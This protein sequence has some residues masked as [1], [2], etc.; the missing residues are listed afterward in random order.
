MSH[1][2][3]VPDEDQLDEAAAEW[4]FERESSF[5][6]ERARAF[7]AWCEVELRHAAAVRR[8]EHTLQLLDEM[9]AVR[10]PLEARLASSRTELEPERT[11]SA[12]SLAWFIRLG[13]VAAAL[14]VGLAIWWK[15]SPRPQPEQLYTADT[16]AERSLSLPDNSVID[17]N[18][19]SEVSVQFTPQERRVIL[20]KGEAHFQVAHNVARPFIVTAG[21]VSVRAVGT[22]FDVRLANEAVAVAVVEG[23]V[24]LARN[25]RPIG[26]VVAGTR[27]LLMAGEM[28]RVARNDRGLPPQIEHMDAAAMR[29]LLTWKNPMTSFTDV[30][31][32][33]VVTRFNRR[34]TT[35]LVLEDPQLG[36]RK[37]GGVIALDQVDAFV[38]LLEQDGDIVAE[39]KVAGRIDLHRAP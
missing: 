38:R 6:P 27:P 7:A 11:R 26:P 37:I 21:D 5:T 33:D 17:L 14:A 32:R 12:P 35:Q 24:E 1:S 2:A 4:L 28:A 8:V 3:P 13:G 31:L 15:L 16:M 34:N 20:R 10:A 29:A 25:S 30:P 22:A 39:R 9:P 36:E 19:G 23:K 18:T